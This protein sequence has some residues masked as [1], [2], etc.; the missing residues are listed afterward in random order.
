MRL[1][2]VADEAVASIQEAHEQMVMIREEAAEL[3]ASAVQ[4]I[5]DTVSLLTSTL[6]PANSTA[7]TASTDPASAHG[8]RT[9]TPAAPSAR[10]RSHSV[11]AADGTRIW[12]GASGMAHSG[13]SDARDV[14]LSQMDATIGQLQQQ[15]AEIAALLRGGVAS[16][17]GDVGAATSERGGPAAQAGVKEA[18]ARLRTA[19]ADI[20]ILADKVESIRASR[21]P[22]PGA[23]E[24]A[25]S[26][27]ALRLARRDA[28]D[29]QRKLSLLREWVARNWPVAG[30][31]MDDAE[32][33]QDLPE[34]GGADAPAGEGGGGAVYMTPA[35]SW[36]RAREPSFPASA[37]RPPKMSAS[38]SSVADKLSHSASRRRSPDTPTVDGGPLGEETSRAMPQRGP[39]FEGESPATISPLSRT[40][41]V[42]LSALARGVSTP[43]RGGRTDVSGARSNAPGSS[44]REA[45]VGFL[46]HDDRDSS[47]PTATEQVP[48][49]AY[50]DTELPPD[51]DALDQVLTSAARGSNEASVPREESGGY[52]EE[53][54]DDAVPDDHTLLYE[55]GMEDEDGPFLDGAEE[56]FVAAP[57]SADMAAGADGTRTSA[58]V[59]VSSR[60]RQHLNSEGHDEEKRV[61]T[62]GSGAFMLD[63]PLGIGKRRVR[64]RGMQN[65]VVIGRMILENEAHGSFRTLKI[66]N[67][68]A[69]PPPSIGTPLTPP[70]LRSWVRV[71]SSPHC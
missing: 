69:A 44:M 17:R 23:E 51:E 43:K 39:E 27:R 26:E 12:S 31:A 57:E 58:D 24:E 21:S 64:V 42:E 53:A 2:E 34:T 3:G 67:L 52:S 56:Y 41:S 19:E 63:G 6:A 54:G 47:S 55:Q 18:G 49:S 45:E 61:V 60:L 20:H 16:G 40:R 8:Q 7:S 14:R 9:A 36:T 4:I 30:M 46:N 32:L 28:A 37:L 38:T 33:G 15:V 50:R 29:A 11:R 35:K 65:A 59:A 22:Q 71:R 70:T 68:P 10:L 66:V 48:R 13:E 5:D 62:L 1:A 25:E